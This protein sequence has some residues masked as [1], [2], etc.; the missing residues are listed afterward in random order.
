MIFSSRANPLRSS[1]PLSDFITV[2]LTM[3]LSV[4]DGQKWRLNSLSGNIWCSNGVTVSRVFMDAPTLTNSHLL[5][6]RKFLAP[7]LSSTLRYRWSKEYHVA[8]ERELLVA[9]VGVV[10]PVPVTDSPYST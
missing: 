10:I 4:S 1:Q 2:V 3:V 7:E 9:S 5:P 6:F 8:D